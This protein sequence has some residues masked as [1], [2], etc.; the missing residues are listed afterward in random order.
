MRERVA[1]PPHWQGPSRLCAG[2]YIRCSAQR[3]GRAPAAG[4]LEL[5]LPLVGLS[6][7]PTVSYATTAAHPV[8]HGLVTPAGATVYLQGPDG[9]RTAVNARGDG[10]FAIP[11]M[12]QPDVNAFQFTAARLGDQSA[13]ARLT[14][15][16]RGRSAVQRLR[17]MAAD[18]AKYLPPAS[19][20]LNRR[21]AP[22]QN[23]PAVTP[24]RRVTVTYSLNTIKAAPP[25]ATG[26]DGHWLGGFE[27]TEYYPAL[28]SWFTGRPSQL[29]GSPDSTGSTGSTRPWASPCRARESGSTAACTTSTRSATGDG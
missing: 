15:T 2:Q 25:P 11:A 9:A 14:I 17:Q 24:A 5:E 1:L 23:L 13:N 16:W 27:L 3:P 10:S 22:V 19:A 20:G 29:R 18:P 7:A 12:L 4:H 8:L 21:L 26:G 6:P 28:E